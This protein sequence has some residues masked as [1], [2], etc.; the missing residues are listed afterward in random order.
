MLTSAR[1]RKGAKYLIT[2]PSVA[3]F[4]AKSSVTLPPINIREVSCLLY[5][6]WLSSVTVLRNLS[7]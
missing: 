2:A 4:G 1:H 6:G 3:A 7:E 5:T